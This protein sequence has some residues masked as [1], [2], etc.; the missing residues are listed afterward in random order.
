MLIFQNFDFFWKHL[1]KKMPETKDNGKI[2]LRNS[3]TTSDQ[4][5]NLK[6]FHIKQ[7]LA[8]LQL[9]I[10]WRMEILIQIQKNVKKGEHTQFA[11]NVS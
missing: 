8:E 7:K 2:Q 9:E 10:D 3:N 1:E 11:E 5:K 6:G 4:L